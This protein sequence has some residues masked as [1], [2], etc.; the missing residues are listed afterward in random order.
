MQRSRRGKDPSLTGSGAH[1]F[2]HMRAQ[3]KQSLR[4]KTFETLNMRVVTFMSTEQSPRSAIYAKGVKGDTAERLGAD[5]LLKDSLAIRDFLLN[6]MN[7][8][9]EQ[10]WSWLAIEP[11]FDVT[12]LFSGDTVLGA[13]IGFFCMD[14][15]EPTYITHMTAVRS[16]LQGTQQKQGAGVGIFLRERQLEFLDRRLYEGSS[17]N[18]ALTAETLHVMSLSVKAS[19]AGRGAVDYQIYVFTEIFDF[20]MSTQYAQ[21]VAKLYRIKEEYPNLHIDKTLEQNVTLLHFIRE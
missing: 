10:V 18:H 12:A 11:G 6:Q 8:P 19:N 15:E 16:D 5:P 3:I 17:Q 21:D 2:D 1:T 9:K 7:Y 13:A 4:N 14:G 20:V